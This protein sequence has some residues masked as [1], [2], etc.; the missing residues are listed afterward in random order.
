M[1]FKVLVVD[2]EERALQTAKFVLDSEPDLEVLT[3]RSADEA[4]RRVKTDPH[5]FAVILV[6]FR[7]PDKDGATTAKELLAINSHLIIAIN[8]GDGSR[9]AL[10]ACFSSGVVDFIEKDIDPD[11]F[12]SKIRSFCKKFA[13][14]A[15]TFDRSAT[16]SENEKIIQSIGMIGCSRSLVDV[17]ELVRRAAPTDCNILIHGESGTGKELVARAIHNLSGRR[18]RPFVPINVGAIPENL[19]ESDL[20]GHEKGAFTGADRQKI[21]KLKF[22][23]GG[24]VF[25]DEIGEMKPDLQVKLLRVLQEGEISPVGSVGAI[26][27][28]VRIVAA[29][30]RN[31]EEMIREGKFREDLF[32]RL[33][34]LKI[35][36]PPLRERPDDIQTLVAHFQKRFK[37]ER[38]T[39]LMKTIRYMERYPWR[40]N[41]RELE[42]EMEKLMTIVP[43]D[44]IEPCHLSGKFFEEYGLPG[45]NE[46]ECTHEEFMRRLEEKEKQ[47]LLYHISKGRSLRESITQRMKAKF[48]TIH[49]RMKRFGILE[50]R[51][52]MHG[53]R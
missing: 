27:V 9:E 50:T 31:L 30:H 32:Y 40:G 18:Q 1:R 34:V 24:T 8:S 20:F 33:N 28:N 52:D 2:D 15:Q 37:A 44:R 39:I 19:L 3:A 43:A 48:A 16:V 29:T 22:A 6:D 23:D 53:L 14:T 5:G 12:R 41:I 51:G 25:L 21:G 17:A 4:I 26:K 47:Y 11:E 45:T 13:E 49:G 35:V 46:F 38:K 36:I 10:K 7:M 42:N